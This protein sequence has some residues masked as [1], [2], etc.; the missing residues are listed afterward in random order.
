MPPAREANNPPALICLPVSFMCLPWPRG[1]PHSQLP[2]YSN[3]SRDSSFISVVL[4]DNISIISHDYVQ[5]LWFVWSV[6][7]LLVHLICPPR[8]VAWSPPPVVFAIHWLCV[9]F[10]RLDV[11]LLPI[12]LPAE[13]LL[14]INFIIGGQ[15]GGWLP[16]AVVPIPSV[17]IPVVVVGSPFPPPPVV[18]PIPF[19]SPSR[20]LPPPFV[21]PLH[22]RFPSLASSSKMTGLQ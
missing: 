6:R 20:V 4:L 16:L 17:L 1:F 9:D 18:F 19:V 22:S 7:P 5:Y 2:R 3:P 13:Q 12:L 21:V 15:K 14:S 10:P 11:V 8:P